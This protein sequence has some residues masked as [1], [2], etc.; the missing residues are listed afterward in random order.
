[1]PRRRDDATTTRRP[2][3]PTRYNASEPSELALASTTHGIAANL[4]D[5]RSAVEGDGVYFV[6]N[7]VSTWG[8]ARDGAGRR[9]ARE[10]EG[11]E[12]EEGGRGRG[13]SRGGGVAR[14]AGG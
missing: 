10:E 11:V 12:G 8:G 14:T 7:E 2:S 1:M 5:G 4:T 9:G 6:D 13:G 3:R